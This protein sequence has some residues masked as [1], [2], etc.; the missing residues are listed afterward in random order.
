MDHYFLKNRLHQNRFPYR[1]FLKIVSVS[2]LSVSL[3]LS[4]CACNTTSETFD[5]KAGKGVGCKSISE[6]NRMVDQGVLGQAGWG[7]GVNEVAPSMA[8]PPSIPVISEVPFSDALTVHRVQEEHV[9]VWMAPFQDEWGN[10]HEGSVIHTVLKPG[11][12][13]LTPSPQRVSDPR[14]IDPRVANPGTANPEA[15]NPKTSEPTGLGLEEDS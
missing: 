13:Q 14:V 10:L 9:R 4:L 15:A 8:L 11:Y 7:T 12:W 2:A 3:S 1:R 6:V 5:C